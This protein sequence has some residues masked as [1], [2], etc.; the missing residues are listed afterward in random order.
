LLDQTIKHVGLYGY[1]YEALEKFINWPESHFE[2]LEGLEQLR[3]LENGV[4][5]E[6]VRVAPPKVN[7]SGIDSPEDLALAEL[8]I[9]QRG[10]PFA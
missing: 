2:K 9:T 5:I 6:C 10:D 3:L 7:I 4:S 8:L 1:K